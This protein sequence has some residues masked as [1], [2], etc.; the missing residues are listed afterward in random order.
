MLLLQNQKRYFRTPTHLLQKLNWA[1][2]C[3]WHLFSPFFSTEANEEFQ[4]HIIVM[5][6]SLISLCD[7]HGLNTQRR[8][9]DSH[10][11]EE[12]GHKISR[13]KGQWCYSL[14][15]K[16]YLWDNRCPWGKVKVEQLQYQ[17]VN[18]HFNK[19]K[20]VICRGKLVQSHIFLTPSTQK[21]A[22]PLPFASPKYQEDRPWKGSRQ[23]APPKHPPSPSW[24]QH[25]S[26]N[27]SSHLLGR[28]KGCAPWWARG[29]L[30]SLSG[31][32]AC[33]KPVAF[34]HLRST[35][36]EWY[37]EGKIHHFSKKKNTTS[38]GFVL[39]KKGWVFAIFTAVLRE[40]I[41]CIG[42]W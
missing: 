38:T 24:E 18:L 30:P 1:E 28:G 40:M 5:H 41:E 31:Q 7:V 33:N 3:L 10:I 27:T 20:F 22:L 9:I 25:S 32:P 26:A 37:A 34:K 36:Q 2:I 16:T 29:F 15:E 17:E 21:A 19:I 6:G 23:G 35:K 8:Y 4:V 42:N 11:N 12:L 39:F 14:K 13:R